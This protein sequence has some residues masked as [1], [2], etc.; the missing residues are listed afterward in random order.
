MVAFLILE[1]NPI[2][3]KLF[4]DSLVTEGRENGD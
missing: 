3:S 1:G 4:S 2:S